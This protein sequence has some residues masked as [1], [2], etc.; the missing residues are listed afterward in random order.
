MRGD[1]RTSWPTGG[2]A[3]Y[4]NFN[5]TTNTLYPSDVNNYNV[6]IGTNNAGGS[7]LMVIGTTTIIGSASI[8]Q[9]GTNHILVEPTG[10]TDERGIIF[11]AVDTELKIYRPANMSGWTVFRSTSSAQGM[12][13]SFSPNEIDLSIRRPI[14]G[15]RALTDEGQLWRSSYGS[16]NQV[17]IGIGTMLPQERLDVAY[18][19]IR[20][21]GSSTSAGGGNIIADTP[22]NYPYGVV[23]KTNPSWGPWARQ[24]A[25]IGP[26]NERLGALIARGFNSSS[27]DFIAI[28]PGIATSG[29][30]EW[31]HYLTI[32]S[33]GNV[34]IGTTRPQY[35]LH[36]IGTT[37]VTA[38]CLNGVCR[39]SWPT[40]GGDGSGTNYWTL[41]G[42]NL[43]V[44]STN[45][46][47]GIGTNNPLGKFDVDTGPGNMRFSIGSGSVGLFDSSSQDRLPY[48]QWIGENE[49]RAMYLGWGSV[50]NKYVEMTMENGYD[51]R[52]NG[53]DEK[54]IINL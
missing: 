33:S 8:N 43:Y 19:N 30:G 49:K 32:K 42:N 4:W 50:S 48:I 40:G 2:G 54:V 38:L 41:S 12:G 51:F 52:W 39:S 27:L 17:R 15:T 26:N 9:I 1:C 7:R 6:A 29:R 37:S 20:V 24:F 36:V 16:S 5:S 21:F 14:T 53:K 3:S 34:G 23:I 35:K 18:G 46:R 31:E 44:S 13:F 25:F 47:V 10:P 22:W 11:R 45:W 28:G